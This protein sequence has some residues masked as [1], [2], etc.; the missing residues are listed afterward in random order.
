MGQPLKHVRIPF[1][2]STYYLE[3][4]LDLCQQSRGS[5]ASRYGEQVASSGRPCQDEGFLASA[6]WNV[7]HRERSSLLDDFA[8]QEGMRT[9]L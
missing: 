4:D 6:W 7:N 3:V 1:P 2:G 8:K 9:S 5:S